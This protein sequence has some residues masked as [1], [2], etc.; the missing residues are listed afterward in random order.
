MNDASAP[1]A[2]ALVYRRRPGLAGLVVKNLFLNIVTLWFYRFWA[3][4]NWR[5]HIWSNATL[6]G[7]PVEYAGTG[8]EM[9]KGFLVAL[10]VLAPFFIVFGAWEAAV[11]GSGVGTAIETFVYFAAL[12]AVILAA[13]FYARRYR[14]SRTRWRGVALALDA[15]FADYAKFA[16]KTHALNALTLFVMTPRAS[17]AVEAWLVS[18]TRFGAARF[19]CAPDWRPAMKPWLIAWGSAAILA[20]LAWGWRAR[21][22]GGAIPSFG[23]PAAHGGVLALIALV[24][25]STFAAYRV[26]TFRATIA[27]STLGGASF[28]SAARA[29]TILGMIVIGL[30]ALFAFV[31]VV[32]AAIVGAIAAALSGL[33]ED[34]AGILTA[35]AGFAG[36]L[37]GIFGFTL[38]RDVWVAPWIVDHLVNSVTVANPDALAAIAAGSEDAMARGE[39]LADSFDVGIG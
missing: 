36:A 24:A 38:I 32:V 35:L 7:D 17:L 39:G 18:R 25:I 9:F 30:L 4:T 28:S 37:T 16:L 22:A 27:G 21:F 5:R 10:A 23:L 20:L 31:A 34:M 15:R 14:L 6:L 13:G 26:A 1:P 2:S 8:W 19:E 3:K 33:N 11:A 12:Y 29:A